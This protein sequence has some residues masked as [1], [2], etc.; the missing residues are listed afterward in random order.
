MFH[1][2]LILY[3]IFDKL[4]TQLF[5]MFSFILISKYLNIYFCI[6][7][8]LICL[9]CFGL[10]LLIFPYF[11]FLWFVIVIIILLKYLLRRIYVYNILQLFCWLIYGINE[12]LRKVNIH[13]DILCLLC[14]LFLAILFILYQFLLSNLLFLLLFF[15]NLYLFC[16]S[17]IKFCL[18]IKILHFFRLF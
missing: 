4:N 9:N 12:V 3:V 1:I 2:L 6:T 5:F 18:V 15:V 8:F 14:L 10:L 13:Y 11:L 16:Y 17:L 7:L